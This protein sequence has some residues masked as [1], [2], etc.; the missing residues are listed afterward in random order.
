MCASMIMVG[1]PACLEVSSDDD[2][3]KLR[4]HLRE[5]FGVEV[6]IYYHMPKHE[7]VATTTGYGRVSHQVYNKVD[8]YYKF[9]D[10]INQLVCDG[11]TCA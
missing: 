10:A 4:T 5:K 11:F 3:L 6:H 2:A 1:I 7:E 8:D 9:R